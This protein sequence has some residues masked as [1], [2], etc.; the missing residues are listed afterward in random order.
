MENEIWKDIEGYEGLYQVSNLGRVKSLE[1]KVST[2]N[3]G[4]KCLKHIDESILKPIKISNG[5]ITINLYINGIRKKHFVHRLVANAFIPNPNNYS[6][7]NH[8]DENKENNSVDNLEW[9]TSKYNMN[10]GTRNQRASNSL[11]NGKLS[12]K[13]FQYNLNGELV[14]EWISIKEAARNG[15]NDS[16]ITICCKGIRP[17]HKGFIWKYEN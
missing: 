14:N 7:V 3:N 8:K 10:F 13:V 2:I 16:C 1:R 5:Y 4:T 12:K 11:T 6:Q 15:F 9:C 17:T